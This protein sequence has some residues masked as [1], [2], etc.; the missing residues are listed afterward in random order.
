MQTFRKVRILTTKYRIFHY[1]A[2]LTKL[3]DWH[4]RVCLFACWPCRFCWSLTHWGLPIWFIRDLAWGAHWRSWYLCGR[5]SFYARSWV[6]AASG[7]QISIC[8]PRWSVIFA[9]GGPWWSRWGHRRMRIP[10]WEGGILHSSRILLLCMRGCRG[11][12]CWQGCGPH[13]GSWR[14]LV[15]L[16]WRSWFFSLRRWAR[17]I[18]AS[19][20]R[21]RRRRPRRPLPGFRNYS[22]SLIKNYIL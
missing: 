10:W 22:L 11:L 1:R 5:Y 18:C 12:W 21:P 4:N 2:D 9:S 19:L 15:S 6:R 20:C 8:L 3:Q 16:S 13:W 14:F 7:S 17:L